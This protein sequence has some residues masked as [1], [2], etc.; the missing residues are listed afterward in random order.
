MAAAVQTVDYV[1]EAFAA[2][3]KIE[4]LNDAGAVIATLSTLMAQ[5]GFRFF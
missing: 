4:R 5:F 1:K 2:L 3:D